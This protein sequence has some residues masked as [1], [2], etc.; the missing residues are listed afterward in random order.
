VD[1]RTPGDRASTCGSSMMPIGI[2][3]R[4]NGEL[5]LVHRCLGCHVDRHN[6]VA[7]DDDLDLVLDLPRIAPHD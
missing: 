4:P 2:Y 5:A 1:D 7:A 6:R 3:S